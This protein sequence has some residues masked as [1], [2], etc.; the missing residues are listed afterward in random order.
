MWDVVGAAVVVTVV[1]GVVAPLQTN[2]FVSK[3][4]AGS[5][6]HLVN[7]RRS[8]SILAVDV[9]VSGLLS[10]VVV[11]A[12]VTEIGG[13]DDNIAVDGSSGCGLLAVLAVKVAVLV[14]GLAPVV[15]IDN[16]AV[17]VGVSV[18]VNVGVVVAPRLALP[19]DEE[20]SVDAGLLPLNSAVED[21]S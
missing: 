3:S 8:Q 2:V 21:L 14:C 19:V 7:V 20:I 10:G 12:K 16:V 18:A 9:V 1:V 13:A 6:E 11:N 4:H 5:S 17:I 15:L